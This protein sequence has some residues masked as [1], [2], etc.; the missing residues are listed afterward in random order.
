MVLSLLSRTGPQHGHQL[1]RDAE[2]TNVSNWGG[3]SIGALYRE[4]RSMEDEGLLAVVATEQI[5]R[6][7]A[8]TV[9]EIAAPGLTE[10]GRLRQQAICDLQVGPDA[11]GVALLFG[12][13]ADPRE[14]AA[15]LGK[16]RQMLSDTRDALAAEC[17]RLLAAG[18]IGALDAAMFR[19][20]QMQMEAELTWLD[21]LD[22]ALDELHTETDGETS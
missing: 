11:F 4:L 12:R 15:L 18:H 10:L 19:R 22:R 7:P 3:V 6:R 5:G 17:D 9:Y 13:D 1:R 16:R 14:L 21:E 8:R 2:D 20:R